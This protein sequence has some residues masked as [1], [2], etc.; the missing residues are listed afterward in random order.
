MYNKTLP[1]PSL[2]MFL[3]KKNEYLHSLK[4]NYIISTILVFKAGL[5]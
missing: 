4:L 5:F 2:A 3:T 1:L